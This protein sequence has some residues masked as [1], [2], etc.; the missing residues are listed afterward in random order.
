MFQEFQYFPTRFL[1]WF[2]GSDSTILF[3][4]RPSRI[5]TSISSSD[6]VGNWTAGGQDSFAADAPNDALIVKDI[7][8][9]DLKAAAVEL[10]SPVYDANTNTL[11]YTVTAENATAIEL[12]SQFGQSILVI[13]ATFTLQAQFST[14]CLRVC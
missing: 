12:P 6:F 5:V 14:P 3:S 10:F 7:Q 2:E 9:G 4:D 11:T 8:T 13:D 1:I